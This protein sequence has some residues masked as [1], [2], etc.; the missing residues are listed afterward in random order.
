[1]RKPIGDAR[2]RVVVTVI[3]IFLALLM[4]MGL[5]APFLQPP[6]IVPRIIDDIYTQVP[7]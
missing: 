5:I 7:A 1:M 4:T 3:A 2:K 6:V